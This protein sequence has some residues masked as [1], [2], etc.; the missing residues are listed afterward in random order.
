MSAKVQTRDLLPVPSL[1]MQAD[2]TRTMAGKG[3]GAGQKFLPFK[4][5]RCLKLK[6]KREWC[7][8]SKS[9]AREAKI[10]STPD[11][12]YKHDGWQGYGHWLGTGNVAG[13]Q[14]ER[15]LTFKKALL[16]ARSLKLVLVA[17][18]ALTASGTAQLQGVLPMVCVCVRVGGGG[19][20]GGL[21]NLQQLAR[22]SAYGQAI[23]SPV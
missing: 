3:A 5:A 20:G 13:G 7:V 21:N 1:R 2:P 14:K 9:K 22:A 12:M 4:K 17:V 16:Y 15:F 8:W 11:K 23:F 19:G 10:P 18:L 6:S